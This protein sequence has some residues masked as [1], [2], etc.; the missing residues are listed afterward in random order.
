MSR[1]GVPL[2][3]PGDPGRLVFGEEEVHERPG[4]SRHQAIRE[5]LALDGG[6]G[7][8]RQRDGSLDRVDGRMG[9]QYRCRC[10]SELRAPFIARRDGCAHIRDRGREIARSAD[11]T[12]LG[13]R[14]RKGGRA[15]H[16]G[17][18]ASVDELV[19]N[20]GRV[21]ADR[22]HR[23]AVDAHLERKRNAAEPRQ[24]LGSA[25]SRD[26]AEQDLGLADA[27]AR[28][29]QPV[30]AGHR[31]LEAAAERVPM[32]RGHD[33]LRHILDV[34]QACVER[35]QSSK[36]LLP[37][38]HRLE[39]IDVNPDHERLAGA[40]EHERVNGRVVKASRDRGLDRFEHAWP[41]RIHRRVID[42]DD[43]DAV[44]DVVLDHCCHVT[45]RVSVECRPQLPSTAW[46][47]DR[48]SNGWH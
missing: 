2:G 14:A 11:V 37:S 28:K 29:C 15:R 10:A 45:R 44:A 27:G 40:D 23:R 26:Q 47:T 48:T 18:S 34:L 39:D 3:T 46:R 41:E 9:R 42:R 5:P 20:T 16:E 32:D 22:R 7:I 6:S 35:F 17:V 13:A 36:R 30:M 33:R 25:R 21:R 43:G 31:E 1:T 19:D 38:R 8:E 4:L 12:R 24:A